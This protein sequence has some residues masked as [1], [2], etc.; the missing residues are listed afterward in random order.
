MGKIPSLTYT[1]PL[2]LDRLRRQHEYYEEEILMTRLLLMGHPDVYA[3]EYGIVAGDDPAQAQAAESFVPL[4]LSVNASDP[5]TVDVAPGIAVTK[6]GVWL[7]LRDH[8]RQVSLAQPGTDIPNVIFARYLLDAAPDEPNSYGDIGSPYTLRIG[9]P[10]DP[11]PCC[12]QGGKTEMV[13]EQGVWRLPLDASHHRLRVFDPRLR[14]NLAAHIG[15]H[16]LCRL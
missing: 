3:T 14:G 12:L 2:E 8:I 9:D 4:V 1:F 13:P 16:F 11:S 10:L 15:E 5:T 6:T 7:E